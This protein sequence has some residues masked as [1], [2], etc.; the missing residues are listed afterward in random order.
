MN[1]EMTHVADAEPAPSKFDVPHWLK[2]NRWFLL[3]VVVPTV[4]AVIYYGLVAGDIY[5][6]ESRFVIKSPDEKRPALSSLANLIQTT[7]LSTGQEQSNEVLEFVRSRDALNELQKRIDI[8]QKYATG[9]DFLSRF[10]S[11][12]SEK[13]FENL[14]KYYGKMVDA[15]LDT[16]TGTAV[17]KVKAFTPDDAYQ[18]N[19]ILLSL[20]ED[21]VNRLNARAQGRGIAEAEQQLAQASQR[22]REAT[23]NLTRYRNQSALIDPVKQASGVV[24]IA[25]QL[26]AQRAA[27]QAQ[28]SMMEQQTPRNPSIPALRN[29]IAALSAQAA[30]QNSQVAG[31]AGAMA[32]KL[33]NYEDLLVEQKFANDSLTVANAA[34]VQARADAQRQKFYLERV[35]E[36]NRPD[37]AL[38][39]SRLL[40][41]LSVAACALCLY[42][43]GWMLVVGILEHAPED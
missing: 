9:G 2:K 13:S 19:R 41:I 31:G 38:L 18:I 14:Y 17:V 10:P 39:P 33:G 29:R 35:V 1:A 28:L 3:F 24:E 42:F 40:S 27:L 6:S 8:R 25:N 30:Q 5:V 34:L 37:E 11:F 22:A 16:Q 23:I 20:S 15:N 43:I 7:G 21:M 26:T 32:S 36:P 4:L 12:V